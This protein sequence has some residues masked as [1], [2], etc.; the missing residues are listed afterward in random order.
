MAQQVELAP[1]E[2]HL[3]NRH[4][5][6][7]GTSQGAKRTYS[8]KRI[9]F[10]LVLALLYGTGVIFGLRYFVNSAA[11]QSTD[12]AFIDGHAG[13]VRDPYE[14]LSQYESRY[15]AKTGEAAEA[16]L[17]AQVRGVDFQYRKED[18]PLAEARDAIWLARRALEE[19]NTTQAQV[20]YAIDHR[21]P[22]L[23]SIVPTNLGTCTLE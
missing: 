12:D 19:N 11:Y 9:V 4:G 16:L 18:T 1:A 5:R 2:A 3:P 14:N 21:C 7:T 10:T 22:G 8:A 13:S 17:L 23:E 6:G 15:A 20:V